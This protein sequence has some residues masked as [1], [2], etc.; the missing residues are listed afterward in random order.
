MILFPNAKIN[1]GLYITGKRPDGFHDLQTVFYP[2]PL[3]D[4][5]EII[6]AQKAK[7]EIDFTVS[8]APIEGSGDNICVKAY[9]LL[10]K[11]FPQLPPVRMHLHKGIPVGAGLGG[12]SADGA[13]TLLLLHQ[14]YGLQ[15]SEHQLLH[16]AL[17]LG[18]DCPFFIKNRPCLAGGRGEQLQAINLNLSNFKIVIVNPGIHINTGWAFS[19][20]TP[21]KPAHPLPEVIQKQVAEWKFFLTNDFEG[22]LFNHFPAIKKVKEDL[23]AAGALYASMSGSGSTV[24]GLFAKEAQPALSFPPHYFVKECYL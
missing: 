16:Y 9:Q 19:Q 8:G 1:L 21:K 12:G 24:F 20:L 11:D 3:T 4:A 23:Y 22:P 15:L 13:F 17:Q 7:H 14:K 2:L 18:S 6:T 10:K 5:L